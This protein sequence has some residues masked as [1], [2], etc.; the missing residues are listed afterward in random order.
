MKVYDSIDNFVFD[1]LIF[2]ED[3]RRLI[4]M[5]KNEEYENFT[6]EQ[7]AIILPKLI[8]TTDYEDGHFTHLRN[9]LISEK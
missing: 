3:D 4:E 9:Y 1:D 6:C 7:I 2:H 8:K 5:L